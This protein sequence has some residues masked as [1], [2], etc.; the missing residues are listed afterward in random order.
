MSR[1]NKFFPSLRNGIQWKDKADLKDKYV[2]PMHRQDC[3][4]NKRMQ[5]PRRS[6]FSSL[7]E[8]QWNPIQSLQYDID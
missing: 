4:T 1:F 2:I 5:E 7:Q 3:W 6:I 8:H